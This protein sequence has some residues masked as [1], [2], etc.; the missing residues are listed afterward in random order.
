[1]GLSVFGGALDSGARASE[2]KSFR[3]LSNLDKVVA[4]SGS[5]GFAFWAASQRAAAYDLNFCLESSVSSFALSLS[6]LRQADESSP[7]YA[8]AGGL[9]CLG[10][11]GGGGPNIFLCRNVPPPVCGPMCWNV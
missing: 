10:R 7:S 8:G 11:L 6:S 9:G 5:E 2:I 1:M 4:H 3:S